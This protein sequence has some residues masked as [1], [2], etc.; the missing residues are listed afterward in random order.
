VAGEKAQLA[1]VPC[2]RAPVFDAMLAN[3]ARLC[4][5]K[6]GTL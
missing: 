3:A 4:E 5:A 2:T 6:F 1:V